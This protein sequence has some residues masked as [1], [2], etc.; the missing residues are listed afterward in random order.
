[1]LRF[2]HIEYLYGLFLIPVLL[3]IFII[4]WRWRKN[5]IK[6]FGDYELV[7]KLMPNL[8]DAKTLTK[9]TFQLIAFAFLI[10]AIAGPQMGSKLEEIKREGADIVIALDVSNS[11]LA[12]DLAPNRLERAK[13]SML[14]LIDELNGD[15]LGIIVF[16]GEAFVQLPITTDYSAAKLFI[17]TINTEIVPTQGTAIGTAIQLAVKSFGEPSEN[18][19]KKNKA[20]IIITD[21]ENHEDDAIN[22]AKNAVDQGIIIHTIGMGSP[23]GSPIP[24]LSNGIKTGY[25]KDKEGQTVVTKLNEQMLQDIASSGKGIYIRATNSKN[26]LDILMKEF[27]KMDKQEYDS[28]SFTEYEEQFQY[29]VAL[30]LL[31]LTLD[32]FVSRRKIKWLEKINLFEE[33][34]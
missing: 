20:I 11:M 2:S 25:R 28:K 12:E 4:M 26:G 19:L 30:A 27:E 14:K 32:F 29:F 8:S 9:L 34:K 10:F 5:A 24:T 3:I 6:R 16:A 21:G 23:N 22:E 15:R 13:Q 17:N 1:M 33:K 31:F 7:L 18:N